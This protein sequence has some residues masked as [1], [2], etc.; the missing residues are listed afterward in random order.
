MNLR[1]SIDAVT[2]L[3]HLQSQLSSPPESLNQFLAEEE[4]RQQSLKEQLEP[5][6]KIAESEEFQ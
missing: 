4:K 1:A 5:W 3:R 2:Q 6:S